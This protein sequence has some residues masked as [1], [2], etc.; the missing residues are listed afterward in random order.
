MSRRYT[1]PFPAVMG[2]ENI[3]KALI[4]NL[5]NPKI[6]GVLIC[7]EKGTAKSTLVR[8]LAE[9]YENIEVVD[10][11][12]NITEDRLE[13]SIDIE[14]AILQGKR[15]FEG[16]VLQK[17]HGNMLYVDEVNLLSEHI[18][19]CLLQ[20]AV[21]GVNRVERE[22]IS[23]SHPSEFV[24][25]G[26]MNPEEGP[27]RPQFLDRFGL[28]VEVKGS[29]DISERIEIIRR[30]LEFE[31]DT[32]KFIEQWRDELQNIRDKIKNAKN[33]VSKIIVREQIMNLAAQFSDEANCQ[34]HRAEIVIVET[35]KAIAA[36]DGRKYINLEDVKE[37]AHFVLP[38]R[39]RQASSN[40]IQQDEQNQDNEGNKEENTETQEQNT[41]M[42]QQNKEQNEQKENN[43][44][45]EEEKMNEDN[46]E[47]KEERNDE[48]DELNNIT[49]DL[50]NSNENDSSEDEVFD[51]GEVFRVK[52]LDISPLDKKKRNGSGKRC[53]TKTG[54][55]QGRYVRYTYPKEK[56]KD[57]AFDA[58]L[59][60]A[61]P[62]QRYRDNGELALSI[63]RDDIR[64]KIREKRTGTTILFVV[65]ASGSMGAKK[66]MKAVKGAVLSLLTDAYQKRDKVG[67]VAF[68][69]NSAELLLGIT[70]SVDLAQKKLIE[71]PTGGKTPLGEGLLR[72]YEIL[73]AAKIKDP[74][75]VPLMVLVSD[76]RANY[77]TNGGEPMK[78]ALDIAA[79]IKD[80]GIQ[81]L[82]V[83]SEE[84]FI[85]LELAK[86]ISEVLGAQYYKLE[87]L[88]LCLNL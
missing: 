8:G 75:M 82:V 31:N 3:K 6:G 20:T 26:T 37:A 73:K 33:L 74:D 11:P 57:L 25:I 7:G 69:K 51:V 17:V 54:S 35:A 21:S 55:T 77:S 66:R 83:D 24:L 63:A 22:G 48:D 76:G 49:P 81:A 52:N 40:D 43:N 56:V 88:N 62:Y 87:E 13:G 50:K 61:A 38:H 71:L 15:C 29:R 27:L 30:R 47:E 36:L 34:G 2:Q 68:R 12:L 45:T 18:V 10:L 39:M 14:K 80:E 4:F 46:K 1:F 16:G 44:N 85:K 67:M 9:L 32:E 60:A 78:E 53:R 70:R 19:N 84:G 23:Y 5:I 28:Y 79:K 64:E 72:G 65:D 58:T 86:D 41:E 59:R 42:D